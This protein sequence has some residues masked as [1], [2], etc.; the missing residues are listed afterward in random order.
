MAPNDEEREMTKNQNLQGS[1]PLVTWKLKPMLDDKQKVL[2]IPLVTS[3]I[4]FK[5]F[6]KPAEFN[7]LT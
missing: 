1:K 4:T 2:F 5:V 6:L 7:N 3:R